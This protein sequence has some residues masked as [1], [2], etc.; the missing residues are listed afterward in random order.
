MSSRPKRKKA[1]KKRSEQLRKEQL[2]RDVISSSVGRRSLASSM[3]APIRARMDYQAVGRKT[4]L[5]DQMPDPPKCGQCGGPLG[6]G[7]KKGCRECLI[8]EVMDL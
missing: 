8:G 7:A 4:F 1:W 6:T 3:I 5:V 2:I